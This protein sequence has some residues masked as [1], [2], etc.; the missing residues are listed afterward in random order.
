MKP[1]KS[2]SIAV[3]LLLAA[4]ITFGASRS[5]AVSFP[6][7]RPP[8]VAEEEWVSIG[9]RAGFV[10][11]AADAK[12]PVAELYVRTAKGWAHSRLENPVSP[13]R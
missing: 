9:T 2:A 12:V 6:P 3:A 7:E 10:L 1:F 4:T 11:R 8:G 13:I 5:G